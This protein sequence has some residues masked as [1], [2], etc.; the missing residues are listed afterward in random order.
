KATDTSMKSVRDRIAF[1]LKLDL[2]REKETTKNKLR[3]KDIWTELSF[4]SIFTYEL[5]VLKTQK[6][7]VIGILFSLARLAILL[8][9]FTGIFADDLDFWRGFWVLFFSITIGVHL[10]FRKNVWVKYR[11]ENR[12]EYYRSKFANIK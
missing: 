7:R 3:I 9:L 5:L 1:C 12:E 4:Y 2:K 10:L 11:D 8:M 6:K